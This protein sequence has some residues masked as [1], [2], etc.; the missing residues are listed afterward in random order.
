MSKLKPVLNN[1]SKESI[2][3]HQQQNPAS[4]EF[5]NSVAIPLIIQKSC[6]ERT[7]F[8]K[9]ERA[10]SPNADLMNVKASAQNPLPRG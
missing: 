3:E 5:K 8:N 7:V 6:N 1:P 9:R 2:E 4:T 10:I